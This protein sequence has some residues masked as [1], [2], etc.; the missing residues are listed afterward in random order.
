[1]RKGKLK[2]LASLG[3]AAAT[4]LLSLSGCGSADNE[5]K[6]KIFVIGQ[7]QNMQF[8]TD[9]EAGASDAGEELGYDVTYEASADISKVAE[10]S[11]LIDR[12]ISEKYDA[13]C[14]APNNS[15]ALND[16][17]SDAY[18]AGLKIFTIDADIDDIVH[19]Q[20]RH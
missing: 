9:L 6:Y 16:K 4:A 10:Q 12:A 11:E 13:I 19:A 1:M 18:N 5:K 14:I 15:T 8:W 2:R 17:L 7:S 3:I 20:F